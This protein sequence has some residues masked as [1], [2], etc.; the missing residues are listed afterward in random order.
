MTTT[1][2]P[3]TER[4]QEIA[5]AVLKIVGER[6]LTALT[7]A[8]V[9]EEIGVTSGAIFRHVASR[10]AMLEEAVRHAAARIEAT[11]PEPSLPPLDRLLGLARNRARLLASE[12]G[13]AW[14]L[15]SEQ[16]F[17]T[18]PPEAVDRLR[19]VAERSAKYLLDALRDGAG[20]GVVRDDV[21]PEALLVI[22]KGAIHALVPMRGI[23]KGAGRAADRV[24]EALRLLLSPTAT[25]PK[26]RR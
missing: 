8:A 12:P 10:E 2:K 13:L 22:V 1:R 9:A 6:G 21:E 26:K 15:L 16:A 23:H 5:R 7:T 11:F 4:R 3:G 14:L 18:L 24:L 20:Q 19:G 17:L 25:T